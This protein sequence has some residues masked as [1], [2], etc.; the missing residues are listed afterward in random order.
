MVSRNR[1]APA[2]SGFP[3]FVV[4]KDALDSFFVPP[5]PKST[6]Y[7]KVNA[8]L[9]IPFDGLQG[10]YYLNESL[11][12]MGLR[13]VRECPRTGKDIS[14]ED[15]T[16]LAFT[17]IDPLLFPP[18]PWLLPVEVLDLRDIDHARMIANRYRGKIMLMEN[19][20]LKL[21]YFAGVLDGVVKDERGI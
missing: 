12:R 14:L 17:F 13:E 1:K 7:D 3:E 5:L 16:R 11:R 15:I 8:G 21:Q 19:T 20:V 6:F 9:I 10:R 18:P 4:T 2:P